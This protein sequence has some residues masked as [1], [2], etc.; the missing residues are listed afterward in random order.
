MKT[1]IFM[2]MAA[3]S[4]LLL[5]TGCFNQSKVGQTK[6]ITPEQTQNTVKS[7]N[8][9]TSSSGESND[10]ISDINSYN[11]ID[12]TSDLDDLTSGFEGL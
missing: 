9:L 1:K 3:M 8:V 4:I 7:S 11:S 2:I 5:I 12:D 10:V 6:Y